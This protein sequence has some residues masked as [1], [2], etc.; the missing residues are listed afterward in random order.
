MDD[1]TPSGIPLIVEQAVEAED[2]DVL[3]APRSEMMASNRK[4]PVSPQPEISHEDDEDDELDEIIDR[5]VQ[6]VK[7]NRGNQPSAKRSKK[8]E[9]GAVSAN[10]STDAALSN[11]NKKLLIYTGIGVGAAAIIGGL[12]WYFKKE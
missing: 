11:P 5:V 2:E 8:Q 9:L 7:A 4:K 6:V 1:M 10:P 12:W 3:P